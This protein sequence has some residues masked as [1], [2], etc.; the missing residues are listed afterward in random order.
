LA[1]KLIKELKGKEAK[2]RIKKFVIC[3]YLEFLLVYLI[4]LYNALVDN[5]FF[6]IFIAIVNFAIGFWAAFFISQ[7]IG[8]KWEWR[9]ANRET[10]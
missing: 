10:I 6:K 9:S 8:K 7:S 3:T 2:K 1:Y 4:I 5:L